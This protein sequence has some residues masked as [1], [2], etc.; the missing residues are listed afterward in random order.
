MSEKKGL[1]NAYTCNKLHSI[2]TINVHEGTT[3]MFLSCPTCGGRSV[4]RMG[5]IDK[6]LPVTHEWYKPT[7]EELKADI[8]Q[9][10]L[11]NNI[12]DKEQISFYE[13]G[14]RDHVKMGGLLLRKIN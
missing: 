14:M 10:L 8:K 11:E 13:Y 6:D 4:S 5:D 7:E 9:G 12:K 2:V 1:K 3:P